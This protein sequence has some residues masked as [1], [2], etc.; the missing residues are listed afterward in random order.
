[1]ALSL[2]QVQDVCYSG[3]T[4]Q[5]IWHGNLPCRHLTHE[6]VDGEYKAMCT[7][8]VKNVNKK[9]LSPLITIGAPLP[10]NCSGY[11]Y[12]KHIEQGYD[13]T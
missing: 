6:F 4:N 7:K 2:A 5:G 9:K 10:D 11:R 12:M 8:F 13:I 3:S 1:M